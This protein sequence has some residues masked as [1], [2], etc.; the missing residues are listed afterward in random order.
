LKGCTAATI[1][2]QKL[3]FSGQ[4]AE[5]EGVSGVFP[6]LVNKAAFVDRLTLGVDG[7]I[8]RRIDP[9]FE[10][11]ANPAIGGPGRPYARSKHGI[12]KAT[13]NP[14][15]LRYG[16][17]PVYRHLTDAKVIVRS[18]GTP[19]SCAEVME[20]LKRLFR[21]GHRNILRDIEFTFDVSIPFQFFETHIL[22]RARSVRTLTDDRNR[23]T[24]YAGAPG[25]EWMLRV[26]EKTRKTTRVEYVF[27][28][29]FLYKSGI[30]HLESLEKLKDLELKRIVRFPAICRRAFED[31]IKGMFTGKQQDLFRKW[32]GHWSSR[33][34]LEA[35]E[36]Y[37]LEGDGILRM[38]PEEQLLKRM[39][40]R[41]TW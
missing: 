29:S 31:L 6:H 11:T 38:S 7:G 28:H 24:L 8:Q 13:G 3:N 9:G 5:N 25:A 21:K 16:A 20:I 32:P 40:D 39:Q 27:R 19:M 34:L 33:T 26:Y 10:I 18:E 1:C 12:Y 22:T 17:N 14:V 35:L 37:D 41:F 36:H 2:G 4:E 15:E 23:Q 30:D